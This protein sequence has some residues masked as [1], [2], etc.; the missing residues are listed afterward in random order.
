MLGYYKHC[1]QGLLGVNQH[2]LL[3]YII[4]IMYFIFIIL[5]YRMVSNI[6]LFFRVAV[7]ALYT[8]SKRRGSSSSTQNN[9]NG[10]RA[11]TNV[12]VEAY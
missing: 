7:L 2:A 10:E 4:F 5:D 11:K 12:Y 9:T 1:K 3:I 6:K 8:C